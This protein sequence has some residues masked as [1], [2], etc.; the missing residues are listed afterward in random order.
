M[1]QFYPAGPGMVGLACHMLSTFDPLKQN[2]HRLGLVFTA[3]GPD[4]GT[5]VRQVRSST[6]LPYL[7]TAQ[8]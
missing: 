6:R 1:H 8:L 4:Y 7:T 5:L 2:H 3:M